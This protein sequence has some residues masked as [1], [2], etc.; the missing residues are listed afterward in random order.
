MTP[1]TVAHQA[2][3]SMGFSRQEYQSGLPVPSPGDLPDPGIEPASP[4]NPSH[5]DSLRL[6][7]QGNPHAGSLTT[8]TMH[9]LTDLESLQVWS[10][11]FL[12]FF[13]FPQGNMLIFFFRI[14]PGTGT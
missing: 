2:P 11:V 12:F 3:V 4:V 5:V 10:F 6:S 8:I 13:G 9:Y 14:W 1:W 7:H